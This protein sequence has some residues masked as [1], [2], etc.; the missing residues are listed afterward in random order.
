MLDPETIED[1]YWRCFYDNH[2]KT[3]DLFDFLYI[4]KVLKDLE[5]NKIT[6]LLQETY[7]PYK[8]W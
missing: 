8:M 2:T 3:V 5:I 7:N 6:G 1:F 4:Y